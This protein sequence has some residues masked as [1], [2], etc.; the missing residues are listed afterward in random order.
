MFKKIFAI[1]FI[2]LLMSGCIF[3]SG[4]EVPLIPRKVLFGNPEKTR[5]RISQDGKKLAYLAP[6]N[7]IKNIWVKTIGKNDDR[8]VTTQQVRDIHHDLI[9]SFD[10]EHVFYLQDKAGDENW[11]LYMVN[12]NTKKNARSYT[13]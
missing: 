8:S 12:V 2:S 11:H 13:V 10:N 5:V 7:N 1:S 9:W 4:S 6:V 3:N